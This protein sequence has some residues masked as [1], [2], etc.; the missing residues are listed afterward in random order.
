MSRAK[1]WCFTINNYDDA[2]I[3]QLRDL[4]NPE[5]DCQI[6]YVCWGY[7]VA[8]ATN[9][10]HLQGFVSFVKQLRFKAALALLPKGAH[11]EKTKGSPAQNRDYC[12]KDESKDPQV[13]PAFE[14][15][16]TLPGGAGTRTDLSGVVE[17]VRAGKRLRDV[18]DSAGDVYVKYYRG[19][20]ALRTVLQPTS[21]N[22]P[23]V[24]YIWGVTRLGKTHFAKIEALEH[25]EEDEIYFKPAGEWWPDYDQQPLVIFDDFTSKDMQL[26]EWNRVF[27]HIPH[28]VQFKG[29]NVPIT[30]KSA[31]ITSNFPPTMLWPN[32][33]EGRRA[34]AILRITACCFV[35]KASPTTP[36]NFL[37]HD[38]LKIPDVAVDWLKTL[39]PPS[40]NYLELGAKNHQLQL[41]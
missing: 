15:Y 10:K 37:P 41:L 8:P 34:S 32:V 14:E 23:E 12:S 26:A 22:Q 16:G 4:W 33:S 36:V 31:Y 3:H 39:E 17:M 24:V 25:Y 6:R 38:P 1:N 19:I 9:T 11:I 21:R 35:Y 7:E 27:N 2:A 13:S 5:G 40:T 30:F 18:A 20:K 28:R 29:G